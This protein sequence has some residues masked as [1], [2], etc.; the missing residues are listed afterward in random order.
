MLLEGHCCACQR[1]HGC[2]FS[3]SQGNGCAESTAAHL[4][5]H[6]QPSERLWSQKIRFKSYRL[7]IKISLFHVKKYREEYFLTVMHQL[8]S[9]AFVW[10]LHIQT[11]R[12]WQILIHCLSLWHTFLMYTYD[13]AYNNCVYVFI[14]AAAIL[15]PVTYFPYSFSFIITCDT[16]SSK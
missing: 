15:R 4:C 13:N 10:S 9:F 5:S 3:L 6:S 16:V 7:I 11:W 1:G 12:V 2:C 8:Q 14:C